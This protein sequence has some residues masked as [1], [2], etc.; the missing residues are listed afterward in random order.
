MFL[1]DKTWPGDKDTKICAIAQ[2]YGS[3]KAYDSGFISWYE[4]YIRDIIGKP[5]R[6]LE[7]GVGKGSS[8]AMWRDLFPAA[9]IYG[10]DANNNI[11][12]EFFD[13][14]IKILIGDQD[15]YE[16]LDTVI[17]GEFDMIICDGSSD[18]VKKIRTFE[19][20]WPHVSKDGMYVFEH[21][22]HSYH[23]AR[24]VVNYLKDRLDDLNVYGKATRGDV[25]RRLIELPLNPFERSFKAIHLYPC[26]AF[27]FKR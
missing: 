22:Q 10:I 8:I 12:P 16:W 15:D 24:S 14:K 6:I 19:Y 3:H 18:S 17:E 5:L 21:L 25:N 2:K 4:P 9:T 20:L 11:V 23:Q 13:D 26:I 1:L 7:I 27:I